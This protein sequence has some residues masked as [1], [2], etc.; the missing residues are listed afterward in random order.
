M[1]GTTPSGVSLFLNRFRKLGFI[2]Y[3]GGSGVQVHSAVLNHHSP[4]L[5]PRFPQEKEVYSLTHAS[6]VRGHSATEA[7]SFVSGHKY[8]VALE[9]YRMAG[10][11]SVEG[12]QH[13]GHEEDQQYS[14]QS[15]A[16]TAAITPAAMAVVAP[17]TP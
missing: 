12:P 10:F 3:D 15:Y 5:E 7:P 11:A 17:T 9:E 16:R 4:G 14:S 1:I 2:D 6:S 8:A 13:V